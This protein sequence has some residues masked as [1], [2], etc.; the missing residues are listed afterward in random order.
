MADSWQGGTLARTHEG[1]PG[2]PR[3]RSR[4]P[5]PTVRA[6]QRER[7]LRAVIAAVA[8]A[9]YA[10]VTVADIVRRA[11]VSRA[12]F[13]A[14]FTDKEDCFLSATHEGGR[15]MMDRVV[16]AARALP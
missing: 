6:S 11:R 7:L 1:M 5:A 14:H 3:G 15:L 13:Y 16:A 9:G 4:L 8:E 12:A 2:L 10:S